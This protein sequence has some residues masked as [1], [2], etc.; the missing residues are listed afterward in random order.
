M[1]DIY[2]P[3]CGHKGYEINKILAYADYDIFGNPNENG[4]KYL[5][6]EAYCPVCK[7]LIYVDSIRQENIKNATNAQRKYF[8]LVS[9]SEL[10]LLPK[11]YGVPREMVNIILDLDSELA[12]KDSFGKSI[13]E[14]E[15]LT[16]DESDRVR[17]AINDASYF[18]KMLDEHK[19][20]LPTEFYERVRPRIANMK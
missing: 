7:H 2:C 20:V 19:A 8:G 13:W 9:L 17:M 15:I 12:L 14:G 10:K 11:R 5:H 3:E 4:P 6:M 18:L 16:S 1:S